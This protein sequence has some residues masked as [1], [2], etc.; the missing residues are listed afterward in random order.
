[1]VVES[2]LDDCI[3]RTGK[4]AEVDIDHPVRFSISL[5]DK[6]KLK[7]RST[8]TAE[9]RALSNHSIITVSMGYK[10]TKPPTLTA[11]CQPTVRGRHHLHIRVNNK[12]LKGSPFDVFVK[13]QP[14]L[15]T[16]E[17]VRVLE[18][19]SYPYGVA[20]TAN[21]THLIVSDC[22]N[23]HV[24]VMER[25][26]QKRVLTIGN[27]VINGKIKLPNGVAVD[28][29]GNIYISDSG[30]HCVHKFS[31][32]GTHISTVGTKG[33][34]ILQFGFP[35]GIAFAP[36]NQSLLVCDHNNFRIQVLSPEFKLKKVIHTG[37]PYDLTFDN[38]GLLYITD[39]C[40]HVIEVHDPERK[41]FVRTI[42]SRGTNQGQLL[43]PRG[44]CIDRQGFIF[45][46]EETNC[47]V[48]V[49]ERDGRF[50]TS[51]G[52]EGKDRGEF[53]TPQGIAVD[54]DGFV[55]VCDMLNHRI[56]VF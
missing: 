45:V 47:R 18:G 33:E 34:E 54:D 40:S 38:N 7:Q 50:V 35:Y 48:S 27:H 22:K 9:L 21:S 52:R 31:P 8:F 44:I 10:A 1:M 11:I 46:V 29:A 20:T 41:S 13:Y 43:E 51:F 55:Y 2:S 49:F 42:A 36:D 30:G 3:L 23:Q 12:P 14:Q 15:I 25:A 39:R 5:D 56:Q 17:P 24:V 4:E 19:F 28:K 32:E 16:G 26:T 37:S 53:N 6:T